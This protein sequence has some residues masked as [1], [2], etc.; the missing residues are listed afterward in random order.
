MDKKIHLLALM[1]LVM[2]SLASCS[3]DSFKIDGELANV[4]GG[5]VKV[6]MR[7]DSGMVDE[8]VDVDKKGH[9][10]FPGVATQPVLVMFMNHNGEVLA[11]VVAANGDHIKLKGDAAQP[12][13]VK[14]KGGKVNEDWQMFR[15]EHRDFYLSSNPARLDA[16]IEKY[17]RENPRDMLSTVLVMADYSNHGDRDKVEKLLKSIEVE[18]RPESLT[19][20]FWESPA[21]AAKRHQPRLMTLELYKLGAGF[22]KIMLTGQLTLLRLWANPQD[23]RPTL[24]Q[25]LRDFSESDAGKD[26][27]VID[28]LAES[29]TMMWHKTVEGESWQHYWAPGGPVEKGIQVLGA[30]S[31]PWY[32]V[33]DSTGLVIYS[34]PALDQAIHCVTS[35]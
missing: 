6:V 34:G 21:A 25:R 15:D 3:S 16:A 8:W 30:T 9:F 7:G 4:D 13:G 2:A 1:L 26:V 11:T 20:A 28:I 18:S 35:K 22:E 19:A 27:R 12:M 14:V 32:A 31:M 33:T 24:N 5:R 23:E 10:T 29:D 17:V